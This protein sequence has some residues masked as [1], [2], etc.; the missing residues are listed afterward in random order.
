[1]AQKMRGDKMRPT[2]ADA[3]HRRHEKLCSVCR[4]PKRE[5]IEQAY[6]DWTSPTRMAKE[7]G[8]TR[9]SIYRHVRYAGLAPKRDRNIRAALGRLIERADEVKP[10]AGSIVYACH[11]LA[12]I[13]SAGQLVDRSEH[14]NLN[15]LFERCS[16]Q[17]LEKYAEDGSLPSWFEAS[18]QLPQTVEK[19]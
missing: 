5:D 13:N 19:P 17:E 8:L 7:Y 4:H 3:N 10:N 12:R 1:M 6:I 9:D 16:Q 11:T 14:L 2:N 18:A 15:E